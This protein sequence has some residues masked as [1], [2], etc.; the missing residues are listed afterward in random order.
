MGIGEYGVPSANDVARGWSDNAGGG[1]SRPID[2]FSAWAIGKVVPVVNAE[3]ID[4]RSGKVPGSTDVFRYIPTP[5]GN[6]WVPDYP[7]IVGRDV[8]DFGSVLVGGM[9]GSQID[10]MGG[11]LEGIYREYR[12]GLEERYIAYHS[13]SSRGYAH[14]SRSMRRCVIIQPPG[15]GKH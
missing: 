10:D 13:P 1:L 11:V 4:I 8:R 2:N 6:E 9:L 5:F 7:A 3:L 15:L 14:M 12:V